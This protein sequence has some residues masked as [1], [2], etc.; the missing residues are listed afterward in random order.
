MKTLKDL[1]PE[2]RQKIEEYKKRA[3]AFYRG[4]KFNRRASVKYIEMIYEIAGQKKPVVLFAKDPLEFQFMSGNATR[5]E[6]LKHIWVKKNKVYKSSS[7]LHS[8]LRSELYSELHSELRSELYSELDSELDSEL[9]SE[10]HS[11]L[12]SEL[13]SELDSELSSE[14]RS[15]LD[16]ELH[17][18]LYSE[19][20]SELSSELHSELNS[21]LSSELKLGSDWLFLCSPYTRCYLSWYRFISKELNIEHKSKKTLEKLYWLFLM[22]DISRC[23]F[24][25]GVVVVLRN[26]NNISFVDSR[27][28]NVNGPAYTYA[29][30]KPGGYFVNG[31]KVDEQLIEGSFTLQ[32]VINEEN[33]DIKSAMIT[34]IKERHG[35]KGLLD[36]LGAVVV[37]EKEVEHFDGYKE[38]LRLYKTKE[39]YDILQDRNGNFNQPYTWSEMVCPSTGSTYLIENSADFNCALEAAKWLRPTFVPQE[40]KYQWES[41][42]N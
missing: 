16:S 7:D 8:E 40:L 9:R 30:G 28:H 36:F 22:S 20:Y 25:K 37:D 18:E 15:E 17:S 26:P 29:T 33:E 19:L 14:L 6:C 34:I 42:A 21:E 3:R 2:K 10:L 4:K 27:L 41:F 32:D 24:Y 12:Y 23:K 38:T 13:D 11:E 5:L 1:T 31:R 35:D 39:R